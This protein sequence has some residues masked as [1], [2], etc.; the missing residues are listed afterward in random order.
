MT[1]RKAGSRFSEIG[2]ALGV[3]YMTVSKWWDRDQDGGADA[4]AAQ[5]RGPAVGAHRRLAAKQEQAVRRAITDTTPD[6]VKR[7]FALWTCAAVVQWIAG[8]YGVP[9]PVR[10]MGHY[11]ARWG[12]HGV[13]AGQAR[14][15]AAAGGHRRV[16]PDR[17]PTDQAAGGHR[18]RGD[19]LGR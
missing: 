4:L 10:T 18:G 2:C 17:V 14:V 16:A 5:K 7:P 12:G 6:Q 13:A 15:R 19:L 9:L 11:L 1:M 3:D 8:K